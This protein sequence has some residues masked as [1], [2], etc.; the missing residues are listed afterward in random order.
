MKQIFLLAI[1]GWL[2]Y[3]AAAQ[4]QRSEGDKP[5][6]PCKSDSLFMYFLAQLKNQAPDTLIQ[7]THHSVNGR[8]ETE[9]KTIFWVKNKIAYA[10]TIAGCDSVVKDSIY[11]VELMNVIRYIRNTTFPPSGFPI[12]NDDGRSHD[13]SYGISIKTPWKQL[14]FEVRDNALT[15]SREHVLGSFDPRVALT[16][17]LRQLIK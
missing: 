12:K 11:S 6:F 2:T 7:V 10:K 15:P 4:K 13:M 14:N 3:T 17:L 9:S 1:F 8:L 5:R 16:I